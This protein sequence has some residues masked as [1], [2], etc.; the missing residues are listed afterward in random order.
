M[1]LE[2]TMLDINLDTAPLLNRD[3]H[4]DCVPLLVRRSW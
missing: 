2:I 4:F 1:F 3:Q